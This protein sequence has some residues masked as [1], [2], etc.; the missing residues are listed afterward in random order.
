MENAE[1]LSLEPDPGIFAGQPGDP[2]RGHAA[3]ELN[4]W[5]TPT[6]CRQEYWKQKRA[7]KGLLRQY[8][9]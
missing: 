4:E 8:I 2:V 3:P 6:I 1:K 7:T 9:L 5:V